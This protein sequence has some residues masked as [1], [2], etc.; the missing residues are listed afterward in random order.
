VKIVYLADCEMPSFRANSINVINTCNAFVELGYE[1]ELIIPNYTSTTSEADRIPVFYG[2]GNKIQI[3]SISIKLKV[4]RYFAYS[5]LS[6]ISAIR[7]PHQ[8]IVGRNLLALFFCG[9]A[10]QKYLLDLHGQW[11]EKSVAWRLVF[12]LTT[13]SKMLV[14]M[15]FN[16]S[17]LRDRFVARYKPSKDFPMIVAPNG[18]TAMNESMLNENSFERLRVGY[19]GSSGKGRGLSIIQSLAEGF[20]EVDFC[21]FGEIEAN[22]T[23]TN[24]IILKGKIDPSLVAY[25]RAKCNVLIAPYEKEVIM[26]S[27]IDTSSYMSPIKLFEYM[28][29]KRAILT[30]DLPA[31]R[32]VLAE[33]EAVFANPT[34]LTEWSAELKKL[35]DPSIRSRLA[36]NSYTRFLRDFTWKKRGERII[37]LIKSNE[38]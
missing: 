7:T 38:A 32:E 5:I 3:K 31:I 25:E 10:R 28:A 37:S 2:V 21:L 15:S 18:A 27:G 26:K 23:F 1:V 6:A 34:K 22:T 36:T 17:G 19:F 33:D 9:L 14:G 35:L 4:A 29:S 11:W 30:S 8:I 13:Q 20:P 12:Y 16:S 24:N